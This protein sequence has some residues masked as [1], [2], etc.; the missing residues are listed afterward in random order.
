MMRMLTTASSLL[1][2]NSSSVSSLSLEGL[3]R[4]LWNWVNITPKT[5]PIPATE[6]EMG[7]DAIESSID[8]VIG[9]TVALMIVRLISPRLRPRAGFRINA[10]DALMVVN[11]EVVVAFVTLLTAD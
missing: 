1:L 2:N 8:S 7:V 9:G 10:I 4:I 6:Y 3:W 11:N 5:P